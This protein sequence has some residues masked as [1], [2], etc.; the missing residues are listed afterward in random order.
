MS[1]LLIGKKLVRTEYV[2]LVGTDQHDINQANQIFAFVLAMPTLSP[3]MQLTQA[4]VDIAFNA[5]TTNIDLYNHH[6][7]RSNMATGNNIIGKITT[8]TTINS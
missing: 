5:I 2:C 6:H 1:S 8:T 7:N 3:R 4:F